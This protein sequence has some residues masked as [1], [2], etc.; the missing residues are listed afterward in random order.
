MN[1]NINNIYND[2]KGHPL[3]YLTMLVAFLGATFASDSNQF[4]RLIGFSCWIFSNG[5]MLFGF[6]KQRN[7]PYSILFFLYELANIRGIFSN[8]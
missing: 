1:E 5:Y 3:E 7:V 2:I 6:V 4:M 8:L